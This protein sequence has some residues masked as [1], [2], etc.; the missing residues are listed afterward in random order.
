MWQ[1]FR[2]PTYPQRYGNVGFVSHLAFLDLLFNCG[3]E[4]REILWGHAEE[5]S[6]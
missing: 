1:T 6:R 4:S 3:P 5:V 2:H